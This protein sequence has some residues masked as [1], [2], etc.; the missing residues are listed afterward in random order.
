MGSNIGMWVVTRSADF[1]ISTQLK[2]LKPEE[3]GSRDAASLA[4]F[5]AHNLKLHELAS[6]GEKF[7]V[8]A[9]SLEEQLVKSESSTNI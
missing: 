6:D 5:S 9:L 3:V 4:Y 2:P 1:D 8:Q 7:R